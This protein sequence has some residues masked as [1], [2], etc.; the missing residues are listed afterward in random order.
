LYQDKKKERQLKIYFFQDKE[1]KEEL[2][3]KQKVQQTL[4]SKQKNK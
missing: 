2:A 4:L 3:S 1:S